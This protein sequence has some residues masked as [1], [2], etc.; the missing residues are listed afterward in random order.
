MEAVRKILILAIVVVVAIVLGPLAARMVLP[1]WG[2]DRDLAS[3]RLEWR[4]LSG[5]LVERHIGE[6]LWEQFIVDW[7]GPGTIQVIEYANAGD[8]EFDSGVGRERLG[9]KELRVAL[10]IARMYSMV[11]S[12]DAFPVVIAQKYKADIEQDIFDTEGKAIDTPYGSVFFAPVAAIE[13]LSGGRFGL[14]S[15]RAGDILVLRGKRWSRESVAPEGLPTA[16]AASFTVLKGVRP[17]HPMSLENRIAAVSAAM[18]APGPIPAGGEPSGDD[19]VIDR[20]PLVAHG[21]SIVAMLHSS[22]WSFPLPDALDLT[23]LL[24]PEQRD[25]LR[26]PGVIAAGWGYS[27]DSEALLVSG[28]AWTLRCLEATEIW[29]P[30]QSPL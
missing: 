14:S 21:G 2:I 8:S 23:V 27:H 4:P 16:G 18:L 6:N 20:D 28:P 3:G 9:T 11:D 7:T 5:V 25:A 29:V 12:P 30:Y 10:N 22:A 1:S 19:L 15:L 13:V 24:A 17:P 26:P